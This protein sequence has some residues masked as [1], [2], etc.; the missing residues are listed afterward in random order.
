MKSKF[1]KYIAAFF[2]AGVAG[3][4]ACTE[5][6]ESQNTKTNG[7]TEDLQSYD[8]MYYTLP[9]TVVEIGRAHV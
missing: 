2:V 4:M 7:F 5:D 6:F 1:N 8:Y 3:L 9:I